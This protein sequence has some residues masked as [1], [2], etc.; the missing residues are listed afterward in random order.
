MTINDDTWN[1]VVEIATIAAGPVARKFRKFVEF[2][3]LKQAACEYALKRED[4]VSEYL[5][6]ED[7]AE[8]K[9]GEHALTTFLRRAAERYARKEKAR[10]TGYSL[11]DE[12]FYR[13]ELVESLIKVWGSG[14]YDLAN[15]VLD[16][17][18]TGAKARTKLVNEGNDLLAMM[19][20]IDAAMLRLSDDDKRTYTIVIDR[21]IEEDT[22]TDIAERYEI[23]YQRVDQIAHRGIRK[24]IEYM[25]GENPYRK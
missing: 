14:D 5:D 23:S 11:D 15:Q 21:Y 18:Q 16:P 8:R 4:K 22:L 7:P 17:N 6:R 24:L 12:Y 25:G 3:D 19:S 9:R 13:T 10:S 2:D 1:D 20:D